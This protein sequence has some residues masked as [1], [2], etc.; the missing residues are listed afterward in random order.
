MSSALGRL[1][2]YFDDDLFVLV[3]RQLVPTDLA[4]S[5]EAPVRELLMQAQTRIVSRRGFDPASSDRVF[6]LVASSYLTITYLPGFI[7][8]LSRTAPA[9]RLRLLPLNA[10]VEREL[11]RGDIDLIILPDAF[12]DPRHPSRALLEDDFVCI[13]WS[14]NPEIGEALDLQTYQRL[15]HVACEIG[16]QRIA[17][18]ERIAR[19][20]GALGGADQIVAGD[21]TLLPHLIIGTSRIA[22]VQSKLAELYATFLNLR[23]LAP[24]APLP[25]LKEVMQWHRYQ[26]EDTGHVWLRELLCE[27]ARG[28]QAI[29]AK[30][31]GLCAIGEDDEGSSA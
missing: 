20:Q 19:D 2:A 25:R 7:R 18:L 16:Y 6:T 21:Y 1:R 29:V 22:T 15:G 24:P 14:E 3:A 17:T 30:P 8:R 12:A 13:A 4:R 9:V 31:D 5:L 28:A 11:D 27:E 10:E 23:V 26:D